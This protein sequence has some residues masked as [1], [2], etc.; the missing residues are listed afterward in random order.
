[1]AKSKMPSAAFFLKLSTACF[2]LVL[3]LCGVFPNID[4]SIFSLNNNALAI[5]V[6]FGILEIISAII[7]FAGLFLYQRRSMLSLASLIIF[8]FWIIRIVYTQFFVKLAIT[9]SGFWFHPTFLE[10]VLNL[11]I[12]F[13][14]LACIWTINR[15]YNE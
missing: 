2:F 5:E 11:A 8:I 14:V 15:S 9:N 1:M 6:I 4:E 3:G 10:W 7:L 13:I 12:E